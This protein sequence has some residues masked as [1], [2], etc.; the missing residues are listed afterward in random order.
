MILRSLLVAWM[1][2][3]M[4]GLAGFHT[5]A[6][7][8][9]VGDPAPAF[10]LSDVDGQSHSLTAYGSHPVLLMFFD[11]D[12]PASIST[13]PQVQSSFYGAYATRGLVVLGI[14]T[15]G[16]SG[17]QVESFADATG[18]LFPLLLDGAATRAAYDV[19][20]NSFVLVDNSATVQYV[21]LGPGTDSYRES[22][23][24][25]AVEAALREANTTKTSTWGLIKNLYK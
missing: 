18:V 24:K 2:S 3:A 1:L 23:M 19:P 21:A 12:D 10:S 15:G 4:L 25:A 8:V 16:G 5:P 22:A 11:Y 7:G 9:E 17:E 13:A 6:K 14:E 20:T